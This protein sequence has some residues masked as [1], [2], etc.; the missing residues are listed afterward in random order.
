MPVEN[1]VA[2]IYA[3]VKGKLDDI[4]VEHMKEF[5]KGLHEYMRSEKDLMDA[6][7]KKDEM[8][9]A[10]EQKLMSAIDSYKKT[11]TYAMQEDSQK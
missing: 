4:S 11:V 7:A 8:S 2:I 6:L 3:A 1:Q 10:I 9:D 5:E